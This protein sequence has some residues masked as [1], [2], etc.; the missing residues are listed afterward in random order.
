[1][2]L[3]SFFI[4]FLFL[5][6]IFS[7]GKIGHGQEL[8][9]GPMLGYNE[10]REI[11]IWLQTNEKAEVRIEYWQTGSKD[12]IKSNPVCTNEKDGFT[13]HLLCSNLEPGKSY[14]Y[15]IQIDNKKV[16]DQIYTFTTQSL[17]QYRTS[18]PKITFALGSCNYINEEKYD[19]P[20]KGY[21]GNYEIFNSIQSKNPDFMM[22]LG[23]NAYLREVDYTTRTGYIHRYTHSRAIPE[24]QNFLSSCHH[25]AIWD[26]HDFGPNDSNG[27]F[28]KKE[29]AL[30]IF[31]SFWANNGYGADQ[32]NDISGQF[33]YGDLD[34]FLLDNRTHRTEFD[35]QG[36]PAQILGTAQIHWMIQA[37]KTSKAAF[38]IVCI[39]GQ[40]LNN[41]QVYENHSQYEDERQ[42][43]LDLI[44]ENEIKG[45]IFLTG[46]RHCAGLSRMELSNGSL[47]YDFTV[48]PLTSTA[49]DNCD[50]GN[51]YL[52]DGTCFA[53]RNFGLIN[54]T[55]EFR[56]RQLEFE[57]YNSKGELIWSQSIDQN[58]EFIEK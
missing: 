41:Q 35:I 6:V 21:G 18:P 52:I 23:D 19:R 45:V 33:T 51:D 53:E 36:M 4:Q 30:D 2:Q 20:G 25:Y 43:I 42:Y 1:M 27:S 46:D 16:S 5:I 50:E 31:K 22:W 29:I 44:E 28:S 47:I 55:G 38:K 9:S 57:L 40:F 11:Q 54:V 14:E 15:Q 48:S 13:A 56:K 37:L 12:K 24:I 49:Y 26:D 58:Y 17:W 32:E 7:F 8:I 39:G 10:M 3:K 34:F